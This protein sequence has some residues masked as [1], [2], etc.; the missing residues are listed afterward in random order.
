MQ[1]TK[2]EKNIISAFQG[3][4]AKYRRI[5]SYMELA[6]ECGYKSKGTISKHLDRLILKGVFQKVAGVSKSLRLVKQK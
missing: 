3:F 6:K 5:P 2:Q 1:L 4:Q